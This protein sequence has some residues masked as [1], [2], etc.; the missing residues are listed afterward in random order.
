MLIQKNIINFENYFGLNI[1]ILKIIIILT[2]WMI[3]IIIY[4]NICF[5]LKL[6]LHLDFNYYY[7]YQ[8]KINLSYYNLIDDYVHSTCI[9][10]SKK[11]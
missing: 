10:I 6:N 2:Y 9:E 11:L 3:M 5:F 4:S 7:Y 1:L 8:K